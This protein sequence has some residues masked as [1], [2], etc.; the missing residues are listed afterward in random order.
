MKNEKWIRITYRDRKLKDNRTIN[1]TV[2][3]EI[4]TLQSWIL[5]TGSFIL[6]HFCAFST[7]KDVPGRPICPFQYR[8]SGAWPGE[9]GAEKF[10]TEVVPAGM[11]PHFQ[12]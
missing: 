3:S 10:G 7:V 9:T 8:F 4:F 2:M 1:S 11:D 5:I 12:G 6:L